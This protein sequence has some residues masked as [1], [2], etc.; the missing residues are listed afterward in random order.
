MLKATPKNEYK[1]LYI[2]RLTCYHHQ[3]HANETDVSISTH[4]GCL[5]PKTEKHLIL[6]LMKVEF[7]KLLSSDI[8]KTY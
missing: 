6:N 2:R 3:Q 7:L 8:S 1:E 4:F 5:Q